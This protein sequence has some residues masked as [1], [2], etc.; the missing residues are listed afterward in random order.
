MIP[1]TNIETVP[2]DQTVALET[3]IHP[4]KADITDNVIY[5]DEFFPKDTPEPVSSSETIRGITEQSP[6][7][8]HEEIDLSQ[9]AREAKQRQPSSEFIQ[10]IRANFVPQILTAL[11]EVQPHALSPNALVYIDEILTT[12]KNMESECPDDPLLEILFSLY[13]ALS[14]ENNWANTKGVEFNGANLLLKEYANR[15]PLR[16]REVEKAIME[17]EEIGFDTTPIPLII[18]NEDE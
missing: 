6:Q 12:I 11:E 2:F 14:F 15:F 17:L 4:G 16:N 8:K 18:E 3:E 13:D 10:L 9:Q 1:A 5:P 7:K